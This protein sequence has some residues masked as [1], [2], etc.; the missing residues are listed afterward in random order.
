[1]GAYLIRRVIGAALVM[2]AVATLVFFMLRI[3][4]GDP[5]AAMLFDTGD[6]AAADELRI[7]FGLDR[8]LIVQYVK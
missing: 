4:P 1:M 5:L 7:K 8:P 3:V 2:V 6:P